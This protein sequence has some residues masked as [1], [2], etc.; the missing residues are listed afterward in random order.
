MSKIL[1]KILLLAAHRCSVATLFFLASFSFTHTEELCG[2]DHCI[3]TADD[4]IEFAEWVNDG[5][6]FED[7]EIRLENDIDLTGKTYTPIGNSSSKLFQ[8]TFNGNGKIVSGVSI[9]SSQDYIGLFGNIGNK[10]TVKNLGVGDFNITNTGSNSWY[11]GGLAGYNSGTIDN[12]YSKGT[13]KANDGGRI[14]GLVGYNKSGT[15]NN[16]YF[17]GTVEG[18]RDNVGGLVGHNDA[19]TIKGSYSKGTVK[20]TDASYSVTGGL[21]GFNTSSGSIINSYSTSDVSGYTNVGGLVGDNNVGSISGSFSMGNVEA[22]GSGTRI[23]GLVGRNNT[24]SSISNSYSTGNVKKTGTDNGTTTAGTGGFVG[25]NNTTITN[26]YSIG[27]V[28]EATTASTYLGAFVGSAGGSS[29]IQNSYYDK[30]AN[31][32]SATAGGTGKT[33][34]E[35]KNSST[36]SAWDF[37][38]IWGINNEINNG[39][40]YLL[41]SVKALCELKGNIYGED[42]SCKTEEEVAEEEEA[43]RKA[44]CEAHDDKIWEDGECKDIP[45]E[46]PG[47]HEPIRLPQIAGNQINIQ[48]IGNVIVLS[49]LQKNTKIEVYNLQGKRIYSAHPEN[50]KILR[51]EVQTK[52]MYVVKA[53]METFRVAVK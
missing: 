39:Y 46:E 7:V 8:G 17:V 40:P 37:S 1:S 23:G 31:N 6:N 3:Y 47:G 53:G 19:G 2:Y 30:D 10:G 50:P 18:K 16:S 44:T 45:G 27:D 15:I 13:V 33:T 24:N 22:T 36:F 20:G 51:I 5:E 42:G 26:S 48:T 9:I 14:G 34:A 41:W 11:S 28:L 29:A 49:N 43:A 38:T 12:C 4:L 52:G 21:V 35:M 32:K 25:R